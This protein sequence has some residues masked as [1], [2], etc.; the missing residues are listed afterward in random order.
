MTDPTKDL[1]TPCGNDTPTTNT[2]SSIATLNMT[3]NAAGTM[4]IPSTIS[5]N[6]EDDFAFNLS[7]FLHALPDPDEELSVQ[8]H[9]SLSEFTLFA[10]LPLEVRLMIWRAT[11]PKGRI[12]IL[13]R[14][15]R[16]DYDCCCCIY[17][18]QRPVFLRT[19]WIS[20]FR[21]IYLKSFRAIQEIAIDL[22]LHR[23]P[24]WV[25]WVYSIFSDDEDVWD[26][27][28]RYSV[29]YEFYHLETLRLVDNWPPVPNFY[30]RSPSPDS[31]IQLL[32]HKFDL[33]LTP[34]SHIRV[35]Q[36][37]SALTSWGRH[38]T[39]STTRIRQLNAVSNIRKS[40]SAGGSSIF[41]MP[42]PRRLQFLHPI[43]SRK[44]RN[45]KHQKSK[46]TKQLRMMARIKA[47]LRTLSNRAILAYD[48]P[49]PNQ[50]LDVQDI[51]DPSLSILNH[52]VFDLPDPYQDLYVQNHHTNFTLFP[53]FPLEFRQKIWRETFPPTPRNFS[54][55]RALPTVN[56]RHPDMRRFYC[57]PI[58]HAI[59][60]ESRAE[61]LLH[62][63]PV[64]QVVT[65]PG[66]HYRTPDGDIFH[67]STSLF[68][69]KRD[70]Y[71]VPLYPVILR[72]HIPG[73]DRP[74]KRNPSPSATALWAENYRANLKA[75]WDKVQNLEVQCRP[76]EGK[77]KK[78]DEDLMIKALG[79]GPLQMFNRVREVRV[80][81]RLG[82][83]HLGV[84]PWNEEGTQA[85]KRLVAAVGKY[86]EGRRE[87]DRINSEDVA[88]E[89][90]SAVVVVEGEV[91]PF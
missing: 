85:Y 53:Q 58:A 37:G 30:F 90:K 24:R 6:V 83:N 73:F 39:P 23:N 35:G 2:H 26:D 70:I 79:Q 13:N 29:L 12:I 4:P 20:W 15:L 32:D 31:I 62:F 11:F 27:M 45:R 25:K 16:S 78:V 42:F 10:K 5:P 8:T 80:V 81:R 52:F 19:L 60:R 82:M 61:V 69:L 88:C 36:S 51:T 41:R 48:L 91:D 84:Q 46:M 56:A 74:E 44:S 76:M 65:Y 14:R 9:F 72:G 89:R 75:T 64:T 22:M 28:S 50:V 17:R 71:N 43:S 3:S 38:R 54:M 67:Q 59:S 40:S 1:S 63:I 33:F 57:P 21:I 87:V 7:L 34:S 47:K 66:A 77:W 86:L 49:D 18:S 68:N 55:F